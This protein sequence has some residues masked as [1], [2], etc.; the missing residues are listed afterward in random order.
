MQYY[1]VY[2][3]VIIPVVILCTCIYIQMYTYKIYYAV[4]S[5]IYGIIN[6]VLV[7][8]IYIGVGRRGL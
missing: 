1:T 2:T 5:V 4:F 6:E 8:D 7:C 3:Y